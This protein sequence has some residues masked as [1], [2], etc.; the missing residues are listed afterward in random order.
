MGRAPRLWR[1]P[2]A[3]G[4]TRTSSNQ[5]RPQP[6]RRSSRAKRLL[7]VR[8]PH[9]ARPPRPTRRHGHRTRHAH[10][11][12]HRHMRRTRG[13]RATALLL[14]VGH[15]DPAVPIV[16]TVRRD[17]RLTEIMIGAPAGQPEF[18]EWA[19]LL[20]A[21]GAGIPFLRYLP[22]RLSPPGARVETALCRRT[23]SCADPG[24]GKCAEVISVVECRW[25][26]REACRVTLIILVGGSRWCLRPS[27][28]LSC[29]FRALRNRARDL[30]RSL[31][32]PG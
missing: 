31:G 14:L 9:P 11:H 22:E 15:P 28:G 30:S 13:T 1:S 21:D 23:G 7:D 29:R 18:V 20:D 10:A 26:G 19:T 17:R 3:G 4:S 12:P 16:R 32:R 6:N 5:H 27:G 8:D 24:T 25:G 2:A